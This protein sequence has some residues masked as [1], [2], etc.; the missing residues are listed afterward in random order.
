MDFNPKALL[1]TVVFVALLCFTLERGFGLVAVAALV[2]I[3]LDAALGWG[4]WKFF[5]EWPK[6]RP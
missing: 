6:R 4:L 2:A 5:P 1:V 3:A